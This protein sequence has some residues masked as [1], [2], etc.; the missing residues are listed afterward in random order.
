MYLKYFS[1]KIISLLV[2][3]VFFVGLT[4]RKHYLIG[5]VMKTG[6]KTF[7]IYLTIIAASCSLF[8]QEGVVSFKENVKTSGHFFDLSDTYKASITVT[9]WGAVTAP[10]IYKLEKGTSLVD[11]FSYAGGLQQSVQLDGIRILRHGQTDSLIV[12][13]FTE[14]FETDNKIA[15]D[16]RIY[17]LE[18]G[19]IVVIPNKESDFKGALGYYLS[20]A[21]TLTSL[22][23]LA[24]IIFNH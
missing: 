23:Y 19:D 17:T 9:L 4:L 15:K 2:R 8:A 21:S 24:Y 22:I 11:L 12:L 6:I 3:C 18:D 7:F 16:P 1:E 14:V 13:D 20:L 5:T 10:G